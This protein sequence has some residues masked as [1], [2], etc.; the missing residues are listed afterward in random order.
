MKT[1]TL[2]FAA[3]LFAAPALAQES[4]KA[5]QDAFAAAI[6]AEDAEALGALY[7]DDALSYGPDGGVATGPEEIGASWAPFFDGFDGFSVTLDQQGEMA[8]G[9]KSHAAWG[10]WT[11][12]ATNVE[13]GE[14][15]T[16]KGRFTDVSVKTD[17][18]WKYQ[19]D[20]ASAL[21]AKPEASPEAAP[22]AEEE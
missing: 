13:T 12:S 15:T 3:S 16:W 10:L 8:I 6:V 4:A 1:I 9:K 7:T 17:A 19:N 20:H 5:L 22:E 18:G 11:M 21:A 2:A 14:A